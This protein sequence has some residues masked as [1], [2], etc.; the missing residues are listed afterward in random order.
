MPGTGSGMDTPNDATAVSRQPHV[1]TRSEAPNTR[2]ERSADEV[3][4]ACRRMLRALARRAERG[5]DGA[6]GELVKLAR[7]ARVYAQDGLAAAHRYG[8][9]YADL[10]EWLGVSRQAVAQMVRR[11]GRSTRPEGS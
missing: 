4:D 6:A 11:A 1:D 2:A 5:D 8:Y 9:S 10:G 3:A 7:D